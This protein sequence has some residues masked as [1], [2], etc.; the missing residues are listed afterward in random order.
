VI[1]SIV[2]GNGYEAPGSVK[3]GGGFDKIFLMGVIKILMV[4]DKKVHF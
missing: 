3:K 2:R 1:I 4:G